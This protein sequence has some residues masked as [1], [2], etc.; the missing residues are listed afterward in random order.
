MSG[1]ILEATAPVRAEPREI[2]VDQQFAT[3]AGGL[4]FALP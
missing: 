1:E 4:V 2:V 3:E